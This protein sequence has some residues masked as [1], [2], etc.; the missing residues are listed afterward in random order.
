[1]NMKLLN[2]I[3]LSVISPILDLLLLLFV[4]P[5]SK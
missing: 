5:K 3:L 4:E 1:M 2:E